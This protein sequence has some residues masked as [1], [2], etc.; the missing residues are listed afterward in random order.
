MYSNPKS[1]HKF[2]PIYQFSDDPPQQSLV[3]RKGKN[4]L[5]RSSL[6][7]QICI[8][9]ET[10]EKT[11]PRAS[12]ALLPLFVSK[13]C[14]LLLADSAPVRQSLCICVFAYAGMTQGF[15]EPVVAVV[16]DSQISVFPL[17]HQVGLQKIDRLEKI[18]GGILK[19]LKL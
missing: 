5:S 1:H 13:S 3:S 9:R 19:Y 14:L 17:H 18:C 4:H 7:T 16:L 6:H 11:D 15:A 10:G 2:P 12:P 8:C